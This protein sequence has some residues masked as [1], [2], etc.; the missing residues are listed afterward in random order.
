VHGRKSNVTGMN[1]MKQIGL[2]V[3]GVTWQVAC[4]LRMDSMVQRQVHVACATQE[5]ATQTSRWLTLLLL[6]KLVATAG[7]YVK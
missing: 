5:M 6:S 7:R 1:N 3:I 4:W 2:V